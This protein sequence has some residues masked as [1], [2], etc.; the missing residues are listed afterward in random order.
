MPSLQAR[1]HLIAAAILALAAPAVWAQPAVAAPAATATRSFDIAAQPLDAALS[2]LA[3]Q[4]GL[5][6]LAPA[7]LVQGRNAMALRATLTPAAAVQRLLQGSGLAAHVNGSTLVVERAGPTASLAEVRVAARRAGDGTTEGTGAYTSRVTSIASKTDQSFREIPQSVS[8]VTRQQLDDQRLL[9]VNDALKQ[10]PGITVN[11][12]NFG[13]FD[14]YSRG[15]Q[16]T[17]MQIDGGASLALGS[18]TYEPQQDMAFYD[19]IE[20]MRGASGLLG[21]MGDPG[22]IVNLA[23]KKPLA[24]NQLVFEQSVGRWDSNRTMLDATG[25]L[26]FDGRLRGRAVAVY[27]ERH[28]HLLDRSQ[29]KPALYGVLEADLTANT[30]LTVGTS[31]GK[32]HENGIGD[33]LPR[34]TNGQVLELPRS[35]SL[36]QPWGFSDT[37]DTELFA[38][39]EHRFANGWKLKTNLAHVKADAIAHTAFVD[40]AIDPQTREGAYWGGGRY[41]TSSQ[42]DILDINLSGTFGLLGRTHELLLGADWQRA[43]GT[44]ATGKPVDNWAVP[45]DLF[46]VNAWNPDMNV[47]LNYIYD[48]WNQQQKGAYGVLR[49]HPSDRL[50]VIAGARLSR[51]DFLQQISNADTAG[52]RTV[53]SRTE[54]GEPTNVTPYGGVIYDLNSQWSAYVSYASIFKPQALLKAGPLPGT[55]LDPV[56]GKS[57]EA[58]F[59]GELLDG[60]LNATFSVFNVERTGTGVVDARY[61][62][63]RDPWAGNCCYLPQG[64]VSSRGFD[65]EIGGEVQPGWQLAAGY[66]FNQTKDRSTA[67]SYST[68]TPKHLLKLSTAYRL[69]GEWSSWQLGGST[70][71]QSKTS[72]NGALY[73]ANFNASPYAFA[74]GG[75]AVLNALVQYR[76]DPN[77]TVSLNLNNLLDKVYYER[78]GTASG[79][80]WYG[81]PRNAVL[82]LRGQF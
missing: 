74:E 39:L 77:W 68:I 80:N 54:F 75:Y 57:Y 47:P 62:T 32:R 64:K 28:F 70:H 25:T 36:T 65:A 31:Y 50:H 14:F 76:I 23:R 33:G 40:G 52:N 58:G 20:V 66:T 27:E 21:G 69:P 29:E 8:V 22:G 1:H 9:T 79:G 7:E 56:K 43:Q 63:S 49:L 45:A 46:A 19:R 3:R 34:Y 13:S 5:Q 61:P 60:R 41:A 38:Q 17:S 10:M 51:Y 78:V 6:L 37:K 2:E 44:W 71:I 55:S 30:L 12:A 24:E 82:T 18:Y 48:P 67:T 11:R 59:K 72:V 42:Q 16:V 53:T 15:F 35:A 81:T 4:A 26:G 73:D